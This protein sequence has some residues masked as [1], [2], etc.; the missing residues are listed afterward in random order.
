MR[1]K[2]AKKLRK[3][4]ASVAKIANTTTQEEYKRLKTIHKSLKSTDK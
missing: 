4:A 2:Q 3:V 1:K